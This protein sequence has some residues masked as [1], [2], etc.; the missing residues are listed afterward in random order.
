MLMHKPV[1]YAPN[2]QK[3]FKVAVWMPV[4]LGQ[5]L[6]RGVEH[7]ICCYSKKFEKSQSEKALVLALHNT[8]KFMCLLEN[9]H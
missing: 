1:L 6:L 4:T 3:P 8:L 9:I 5:E 2:F 7:P